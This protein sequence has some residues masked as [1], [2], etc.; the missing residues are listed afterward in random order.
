LIV[1]TAALSVRVLRFARPDLRTYLYDD[2]DIAQ[3]P[4]F[5]EILYSALSD[6][7]RG[8]A[9]VVNLRMVEPFPAALYRCLL[10]IRQTV[11]ARQSHLVLCGLSSEHEEIFQLFQAHRLFTILRT[12]AEAVREAQTGRRTPERL[13]ARPHVRVGYDQ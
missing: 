12:E 9:L 1:E 11:L 7:A 8:W 3:S 4:L 5:R 6:L 13:Q 2:T 10:L